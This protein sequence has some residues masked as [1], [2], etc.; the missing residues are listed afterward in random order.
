[1]IITS[2]GTTFLTVEAF[3]DRLRH[4][5]QGR[6]FRYATGDLAFVLDHEEAA[7][8][9]VEATVQLEDSKK[10]VLAQVHRPDLNLGTRS[11]AFEYLATKTKQT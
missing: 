7:R 3:L 6:A 4:T 5:P 1:M 10:L 11:D 9:L 2:H 8:D